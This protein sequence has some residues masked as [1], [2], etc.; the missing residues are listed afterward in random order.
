MMSIATVWS[1]QPKKK[2]TFEDTKG[3]SEA[4]NRRTENK[5]AKSTKNDLLNI[6]Y[7]TKDW[8]S[9]VP[10]IPG[11]SP[12]HPGGQA[13]PAPHLTRVT[14]ATN[15]VTCHEWGKDMWIVITTNVRYMWSFVTHMLRNG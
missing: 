3:Y 2:K 12:C 11:V 13:A 14:R 7:E 15:Q 5:I 6:A 1:F 4:A 9:R 10:L 8:A